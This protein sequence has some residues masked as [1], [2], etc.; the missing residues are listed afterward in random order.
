MRRW[1]SLGLIVLAL[2]GCG[3]AGKPVRRQPAPRP[4]AAEATAEESAEAAAEES[5]EAA[6][7]EYEKDAQE[8]QP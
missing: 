3:R 1:L 6:A 2:A 7:E 5:A 8:K 4:A